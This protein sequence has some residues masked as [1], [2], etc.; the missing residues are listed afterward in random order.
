M[1]TQIFVLCASDL[2]KAPFVYSSFQHKDSAL[3][4]EVYAICSCFRD[5][6]LNKN[7]D[8]LHFNFYFLHTNQCTFSFKTISIA[9]EQCSNCLFVC[10]VEQ[11]KQPFS[12]FEIQG[13]DSAG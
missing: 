11:I 10:E 5:Q 4:L 7:N 6:F 13:E 8:E 12:N 2:E 1:H 9:I 3:R